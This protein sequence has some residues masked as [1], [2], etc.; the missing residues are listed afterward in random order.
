MQPWWK[1]ESDLANYLETQ[2]SIQRS[3][4]PVTPSYPATASELSTEDVFRLDQLFGTLQDLQQRV[5]HTEEQSARVADL[6]EFLGRLRNDLPLQSPEEAFERLQTLRAW[7]FWLPPALLRAGE[8][9]LAATAILAHFFA[10]ALAIEPLFPE[11][12]GAYLG[13]MSVA[14]IEEMQRILL[15]RKVSQ[16]YDAGIQMALSLMQTPSQIVS[17]YRNRIRPSVVETY[18]SASH[19]PYQQARLQSTVSSDPASFGAYGAFPLGSPANLAVPRSPYH[20]SGA[21][22]LG[23]RRSSQ[24]LEPSPGLQPQLTDDRSM[25]SMSGFESLSSL[26]MSYSPAFA[27]E[28]AMG[29]DGTAAFTYTGGFVAPE[30]WT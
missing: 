19:S 16:P 4:T 28:G 1:E 27:D 29:Y 12:G 2:R 26:P 24:Y 20:S 7:L 30:L 17:A 15:A 3:R 9:D 25:G 14:P 21:A 10:A 11:I 23:A 13:T 6:V 5:A 18:R 22:S 8:S